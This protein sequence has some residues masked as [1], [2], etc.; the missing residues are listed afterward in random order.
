MGS[1]VAVKTVLNM[2]VRN[3]TFH[4]LVEL[5]GLTMRLNYRW[6]E[7]CQDGQFCRVRVTALLVS[8]GSVASGLPLA[9]QAVL[10]LLVNHFLV[11][12]W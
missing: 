6:R 7:I 9:A 8:L 1:T 3:Y 10:A 12:G 5:A 4:L 2:Q 11:T